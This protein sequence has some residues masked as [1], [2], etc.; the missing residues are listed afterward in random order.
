MSPVRAVLFDFGGVLVRTEDRS[1][2]RKWEQRLGLP[3][4]GAEE[5]VFN[6]EAGRRASLGAV[7]EAA[8]WAEVARR[9]QLDQASLVEFQRDFWS[10]DRLDRELVGYLTGLRPRYL[11][12][13][14]SNAWSG[15][16]AAFT[17]TFGLGEAVNVMIISAEVG[18]AKPAARIYHLAAQALEVRPEQ[19]VFVDDFPQNVDGARAIG[20]NAIQFG[21]RAQALADL[22]T[23]LGGA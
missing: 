1:G 21:T 23:L 13:L 16:R 5:A 6:S 22:Q 12:G 9:F 10:G 7:P 2:L 17:E 19:A 18:V 11:T 14:L 15:A 4:V 8:V 3:E 20:M